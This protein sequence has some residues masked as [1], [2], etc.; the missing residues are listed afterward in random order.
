MVKIMN[1]VPF[2]RIL[3]IAKMFISISS[4][5]YSAKSTLFT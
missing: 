3:A 5:F 2:D 1:E 4:E